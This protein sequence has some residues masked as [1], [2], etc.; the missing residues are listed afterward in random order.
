MLMDIREK[1]RG[2]LAY[3]IVGLISIP[4][5]LWGVGEYLGGGSDTLVAE[6]EGEEITA[7]QLDQA[8]S[9]RRQQL[10]RESE[11]KIT[12]EMIEEMGLK[13]QVLDEMINE[14]LLI[15][16]TREQGYQVPDGLVAAT[17]RG[18]SAFERNGEF[19]REAYERRLA[20]QGMSVDQFE[21]DV[22]RDLL[23]NTLDNALIGSAFV[24]EPEVRQ[25]VA[26]RDQVREVGL[27]R[28]ERDIV[29]AGIDKPDESTLRAYYDDN[30][31]A[32]QRPE[33][34]R[35]SYVEMTPGRL[36]ASQEISDEALQ[37]AYDE[38]RERQADEAVRRARHILIQVG[39]DAD[40]A[41]VDSARER[42]EE[43]RAALEAGET[44]FER[45]AAELS[46]D[47]TSRDHG[48][49][50]GRVGDGEIA[51]SFDRAVADLGEGEISDPVRTRFGWHLIE[52]YEVS[53]AEVPPLEEAR[54]E[55]VEQLKQDAAE[56]AY[57]D[58]AEQLASV[59][60]EQPDSL[61]PAAEAAGLDIDTSDWIS[62]QS[63][64]GIG[65]HDAVR[66]AAF[67][68]AVLEERFN[69]QL[70][71]LDDNH[72][73]VV[74]VEEHRDAQPMPFDE[75][76]DQVLD[77]WRAEQVESEVADL[78]DAIESDLATGEDPAER[79]AEV[80]AASW[81]Q[82]GWVGRG[83]ASDDLPAE[84]L[85]AVFAL[86]PPSEDALSVATTRLDGGDR[87]VV[88]LSGVRA[89]E[90]SRLDSE[91][92]N[93]LAGQLENNQA[94]RAIEAFLRSLRAEADVEIRERALD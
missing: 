74:R 21:N 42:L 24:T 40:A 70:I 56:R 55:L 6:V 9:E 85:E 26:L 16:F 94:S 62:R 17:I 91:A 37:A 39:D 27:V 30:G 81:T 41:T 66:E 93:R 36:A 65:E 49:D 63:G 82:A 29:A 52:V 60:Y 4:F 45:A 76:R 35:L 92:R 67:D 61:V 89:G 34:V 28:I 72:S 73:V 77:Q 2:W 7:R 48:G 51:E 58:A 22:R 25:L 47:S 31:D 33:Q 5:A 15:Q 23:F 50:L 8:F 84:A 46:D 64:D 38:Y 11:Q 44:S 69:S 79:V 3:V 19:D 59:S 14:R 12:A 83:D 54:G 53:Q 43:A 13:R 68:E 87:A 86:T 78:A 90:P 71:D 18:I 75:V 80:E 32:F 57:Y 20:Q 10:I 88:I 1:I